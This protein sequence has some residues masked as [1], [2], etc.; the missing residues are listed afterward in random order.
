MTERKFDVAVVGGGVVGAA[1]AWKLSKAGAKVVLIEKD[2]L[3]AGASCTN[4]GFCVLSY[5][6]NPLVMDMAL[7]QQAQWDALVSEIGDVEYNPSGGLIPLTDTAQQGILEGLCKHVKGMGLSDIHMITAEKAKE[8]EPE[9]NADKLVGACWCPGE[10]RLNPFKLN[11]NMADRAVALGTTVMTHTAVTGLRMNN[12]IVE[13]VETT[14]G[15]VFADLVILCGGAWTRDLAAMAGHDLPIFY[16]RGEA[17]VSMQVRPTIKR[18]ITDGAL[19]N[20]PLT[21]DHPMVI[22]ACLGQT[23]SG[24]IVIAQATSRPGNYDKSNT[25]EGM[26]GV[27]NRVISLFPSLKDI[28]IIRMWSGLVSY[29]ADKDPV[30]GAFDSPKNLFIANSFHSAIALSPSIGDM[31]ADYWK[32][33]TIPEA[34]KGYTPMRFCK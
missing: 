7:R 15:D 8:L 19:F 25:L 21:D 28:D 33:G 20:Q 4:P 12:G 18:M 3:C 11:L 9:L 2:D 5:R 17:M 29:A 24:N 1:A 26:K 10:G 16:E 13:A 31:I 6:E 30:F 22:G 23:H 34:A 32:N 27:A 14:N